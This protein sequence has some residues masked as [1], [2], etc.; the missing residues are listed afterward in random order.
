MQL[1]S[2]LQT[3]RRWISSSQKAL[4]QPPKVLISRAGETPLTEPGNSRFFW[5]ISRRVTRQTVFTFPADIPEN[6][7]EAVLRLQV[8]RWAPFPSAKYIAQWAG[9]RASV[10]AWDDDEA[11][12]TLAGVGLNPRRGT[13]YPEV[14]FHSPFQ[15][16]ARLITA[17]EGVEGQVWHE[18]F[19]MASRWWPQKPSRFE[20]EMF[21]RAATQPLAQNGG[22]VPEPE[23]LSFLETPWNREDAYLGIP[24]WLLEDTRYAA[25]A[26]AL[27]LAP[28]I[29][30]GFEYTTLAVANTRVKSTLDSVSVETQGVRK[31]RSQA[32]TNL[33]QID[34][35]LA[36]EVYPS[37][38]EI[39]TTALGLL[40]N[41]SIK[42][43]E[44]TYDVGTLS[45]TL[46]ADHNIDATAV[47]TA[48]EKS[49]IFTNVSTTRFGQEGSLRVR[50]DVQPK[51]LKTASK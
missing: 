37:Q 28:F 51:Q 23:Q 10:Y 32:L 42:I 40:E 49:G 26:A 24:W 50:M 48:F 31:L 18:G 4:S 13:V 30:M 17:I 27:L 33:D 8:R 12:K 25:A 39:L 1:E 6:K 5:V 41:L 20:W 15:N 45:F 11:K 2:L 36:L 38:Y 43:P 47:I 7:R 46:R 29:F 16:G 34:S 22:Q 35:Y 14:F 19:L 9:N 3:A 21:L 44:W